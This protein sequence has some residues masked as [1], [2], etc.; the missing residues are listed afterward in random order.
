MSTFKEDNLNLDKLLL[1]PNNYRYQD[2]PN[3]VLV[4]EKRFVEK[5]VQDRAFRRLRAEES[6]LQL[7]NSL[8][9][10]GFI[11][12]ERIVVRPYIYDTEYYVVLEG[13]RRVAA[14]RWI[15]DDHK[16]GL[17]VPQSLLETLEALPIII[18]EDE[19]DS[20]FYE[21]L[22]GVR[23]VSGIKQWG[24]YQRASLI[25][26]LRDKYDLSTSSV[27]ERLGL[28]AQEVNRRYRAFKAL[29]QMKED[30]DFGDYATSS[31]YPLFHEAIALP[32]VRE[33]LGWDEA[34]TTFINEEQLRN[35]Y[36]LLTP[37]EETDYSQEPKL[38]TYSHIRE[39]KHIVPNAEARR[40][41]LDQ[42]A[43]F[44]DAVSIA[45][46]EEL[47]R[48]WRTQVAEAVESI[49][50]IGVMSI[51]ELS[52]EDLQQLEEI[53]DVSSRVLEIHKKLL[54]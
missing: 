21:S 27:A 24:G 26:T 46:R 2:D 35:F 29:Q 51:S 17:N 9:T 28:S 54:D 53:R 50:A 37:I 42:S 1:D 40:V 15:Y 4:D 52:S 20:A 49:Q 41:L 7:K 22:M 5:G 38:T 10:N 39:L 34:G 13:N 18:V 48:S 16:A 19:L 32:N 6:L 12:V 31:M 47:S 11:P 44:F 33:W 43:S 36:Q 8:M 3:F 23:H 30:E 25:V 14:L 45:K